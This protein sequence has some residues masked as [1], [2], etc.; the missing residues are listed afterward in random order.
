MRITRI[1]LIVV[2]LSAALR[3]Q[4]R[5]GEIT[6]IEGVRDNILSGIG[7]VVGLKGNGDTSAV[8]RKM[9]ASMLRR[10]NINAT[11][12]EIAIASNAAVVTVQ[13]KISPFKRPG[14]RIDVT[15]SSMLDAQ[16][17]FGG[18][19]I[20]THLTGF[21]RQMV[22]AIAEGPIS[23]GGYSAV[24]D[25]NSSVTINHDTVATIP[26]G[27]IVEEAIPMVIADRSGRVT[28]N[29]KN[30][31]WTTASNI[32]KAI[33]ERFPGSAIARNAGM[34][35]VQV[36]DGFTSR[37]TDF[38]S[39]IQ[40]LE[41]EVHVVAKI[42]VDERSGVIVAGQEVRI[43]TVAVAQG[44]LSVTIREA[45]QPVVANPLT[46]GPG[47]ASVPRSEVS[48]AEEDG[49]LQ[50]VENGESVARLATSLNALGATPRQ[51]IAFLQSIKAAGALQADLE[52]R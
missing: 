42:V 34:V 20:E 39:A 40:D 6:D 52:I 18:T 25:S 48:I 30:Q 3:G 33:N 26:C 37:V 7:L 27:A 36:P 51:L 45:P 21:D 50:V 46:Q 32:E 17:L 22:Y 28:F 35:Q 49:G 15:I 11:D 41:V 43:S 19:L 10:N 23:V 14:S 2:L 8:A 12:A 9:V 24:G 47:I 5:I 16:S 29:L 38:I 31:D 44:D 1:I 13:A 4:S